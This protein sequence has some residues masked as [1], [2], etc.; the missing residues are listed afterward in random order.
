MEGIEV[1]GMLYLSNETHNHGLPCTQK[2]IVEAMVS[3]MC[4]A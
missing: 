3:R 4:E 1:P 2:Y